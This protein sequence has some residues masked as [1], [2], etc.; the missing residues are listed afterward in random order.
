MDPQEEIRALRKLTEFLSAALDAAEAEKQQMERENQL[1]AEEIDKTRRRADKWQSMVLDCEKYL[2]PGETP[3]QRMDRDHAES[4]VLMKLY[5]GALERAEA[6]EAEKHAAVAAALVDAGAYLQGRAEN[7]YT[8]VGEAQS[9]VRTF[10]SAIPDYLEDIS[11]TDALAEYAEKVRAEERRKAAN[12]VID[13][14]QC[15][16]CGVVFDSLNELHTD[17]DC[18]KGHAS[19][20][21]AD[22]EAIAAAIRG[23]EVD[24]SC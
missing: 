14:R 16:S 7:Y 15:R 4:L 9:A 3:R 8:S 11:D 13:A 10:A 19:W 21:R 18:Q 20:E 23:E 2:K 6:A 5:Q 12:L 24:V 17:E 1:Q 22:R